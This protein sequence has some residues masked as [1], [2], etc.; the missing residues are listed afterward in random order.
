MKL[1][2][3]NTVNF[4]AIENNEMSNLNGGAG[5]APIATEYLYNGETVKDDTSTDDYSPIDDN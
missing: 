5:A 2:K 3:L 4:E 1:N